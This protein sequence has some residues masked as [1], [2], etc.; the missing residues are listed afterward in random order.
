MEFHKFN[1][2]EIYHL[3]WGPWLLY[4][5]EAWACLRHDKELRRGLIASSYSFAVVVHQHL[6]LLLIWSMI[7]SFA[8]ACQMSLPMQS[9]LGVSSDLSEVYSTR[10]LSAVPHL[11]RQQKYYT[12]SIEN[13]KW[14]YYR[15]WWEVWEVICAPRRNMTYCSSSRHTAG[16]SMNLMAKAVFMRRQVYEATMRLQ[17]RISLILWNI[18]PKQLAKF[19]E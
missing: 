5:W 10:N 14:K 4:L 8:T 1:P 2:T 11:H 19:F 3:V 13:T 7:L 18:V 15:T 17:T 16:H 6:L 12:K 9:L